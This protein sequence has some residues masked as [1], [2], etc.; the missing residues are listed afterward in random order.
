MK[1]ISQIFGRKTPDAAPGESGESAPGKQGELQYGLTFRLQNGQIYTVTDLPVT[2]GRSSRN[3]IVLDDPTVSHQHAF[4]FF[5]DRLQQVCIADLNS[6]NG[7]YLNDQPTCKNVLL[8]GA[9]IALGNSAIVF[10]D[11]GYIHPAGG[12]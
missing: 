9:R 11:T 1:R 5:D 12:R 2:I 8:D 3:Q 6:V 10:R 7:L 4:V